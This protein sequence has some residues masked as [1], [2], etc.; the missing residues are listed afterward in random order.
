[1]GEDVGSHGV[2]VGR[3]SPLE[4]CGSSID[5]DEKE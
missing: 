5:K 4:V 1:V 2:G 3:L